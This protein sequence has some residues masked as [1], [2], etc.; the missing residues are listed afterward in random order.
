MIALS[1]ALERRGLPRPTVAAVV[2]VDVASRYSAYILSLALALAIAAFLGE[3]ST[4][5]V[6]VAL[7][8]F[9]FSTG[10]IVALF[11][12]SGR[13]GRTVVGPVKAFRPLAIALQFIE[14]ADARVTRQPRLLL[15]ACAYQLGI[16]L[17][18][19]ATVWVLIRSLGSHG[20][21]SGVFASFMISSL[22]RTVGFAPGGLGTFETASIVTLRM[23]GVPTGESLAAT[24]L[25]R[26]LSFWLP[27]LPGIWFSRHAVSGTPSQ[28]V[29][30]LGAYWSM[31]T[32]MLLRRLG[33][34]EH[35][36]S[37]RAASR[38]LRRFGRNEFEKERRLSRARVLWNQIRSP[39]LLLLLFAA[40]SPRRPANGRTP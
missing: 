32:A 18:D 28:P 20:S 15:E 38:R 35:G 11:A 12:L 22:F 16:I 13:R 40:R 17:C 31:D 33:S 29:R 19:A 6:L 4:I 30:S 7:L 21:P 24:L 34:T 23:V 27:M 9:I 26:G 3:T 37:T 14:Q 8:F 5:I 39:L 10:L 2:V 25:F 36:L 1:R